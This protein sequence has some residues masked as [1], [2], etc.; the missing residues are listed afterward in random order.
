MRV[1]NAKVISFINLK[2][3]VGK[4]TTAVNVAATIAKF[5][6]IKQG[7]TQKPARVLLIDLDPQSNA[8]LTLL[9]QE[10]YDSNRTVVN[11]FKHE[12]QRHDSDE[13]FDLT[14][15]RHETPIPGLGLDLIPSGLDLFDIQ[16]ELVRYQRYYMSAT[17]ILFNALNK[18]REEKER[19][20]TH[21]IIDCPPSLSLVTLNGLLLSHYYI[22]PI[23]LDAYSHWG[24]DKVL[25]C[26]DKLKR[27]KANCKAELLGVLYSR[28]DSKSTIEN[29]RWSQEFFRWEQE[30]SQRFQKYYNRGL[31]SLVFRNCISNADI[32]RKSEAEHR[33]L[34][35]YEPTESNLRKDKDKRLHEWMMLS[36]EILD[37]MTLLKGM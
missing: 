10:Q 16:D 9:Q 33:P 17:D 21:I 35:A 26:V 7:G 37:R 29:E 28:V 23:L 11:L 25:A 19:V 15:I 27:C 5:Y 30:N 22:V 20:Y 14:E 32:V 13:S 1:G 24:L 34:V 31:E 18:L 3:G 8:S 12:L 6:K 2:G 4:T 36:G